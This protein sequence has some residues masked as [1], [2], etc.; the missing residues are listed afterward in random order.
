MRPLEA[1]DDPLGVE[2]HLFDKIEQ[3]IALAEPI[4]GEVVTDD[5]T[6]EAPPPEANTEPGRGFF[7]HQGENR[8]TRRAE[9]ARFTPPED[10]PKAEA[11]GMRRRFLKQ[12]Q[13][14]AMGKLDPEL[15]RLQ[16]KALR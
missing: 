15:R 3:E 5:I 4:V 7:A 12:R 8:R 2:D 6:L 14:R 16:R 9:V 10:T 1:T 13:R 11:K